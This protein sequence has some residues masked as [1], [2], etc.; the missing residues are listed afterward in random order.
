MIIFMIRLYSEM[1]NFPLF[2]SVH[3]SQQLVDQF[4]VFDCSWLPVIYMFGFTGFFANLWCP[5]PSPPLLISAISHTLSSWSKPWVQK[6]VFVWICTGCWIAE[7]WSVF[8][9]PSKHFCTDLSHLSE[10]GT[11]KEQL[12]DWLI[13]CLLQ[14]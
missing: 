11:A 4:K 3:T 14:V 7:S 6:C 8:P 10:L 9:F 13:C 2:S 5:P 12:S 1:F